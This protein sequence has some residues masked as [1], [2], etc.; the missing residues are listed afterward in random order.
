MDLRKIDKKTWLTAIA[1]VI[2]LILLIF[3]FWL[4]HHNAEGT[5]NQAN[6][7]QFT[8][9]Q[10]A[11]E[12]SG[13]K[14]DISLDPMPLNPYPGSVTPGKVRI[15]NAQNKLATEVNGGV[16]LF[17]GEALGEM[18]ATHKYVLEGSSIVSGTDHGKGTIGQVGGSWKLRED[19]SNIYDFIPVTQIDPTY[20]YQL[21]EDPLAACFVALNL[22]MADWLKSQWST[23]ATGQYVVIKNGQGEFSYLNQGSANPAKIIALADE[24]PIYPA[25]DPK[26]LNSNGINIQ[27]L[28]SG[29]KFGAPLKQELLSNEPANIKAARI[30]QLKGYQ[31]VGPISYAAKYTTDGAL[32]HYQNSVGIYTVAT[33]P[34]GE[35]NKFPNPK[36]P[37]QRLEYI[38]NDF[39]ANESTYGYSYDVTFSPKQL[40]GQANGKF[41]ITIKPQALPGKTLPRT[42]RDMIDLTIEQGYTLSTPSVLTTGSKEGWIK[43][44]YLAYFSG[45]NGKAL[46]ANKGLGGT[47]KV[48]DPSGDLPQPRIGLIPKGLGGPDNLVL[49]STGD[50]MT[51]EVTQ[52]GEHSILNFMAIRLIANDNAKAITEKYIGTCS[53]ILDQLVSVPVK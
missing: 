27:A 45:Y 16:R 33:V 29:I 22:G 9:E 5:D 52:T 50:T 38:T 8:Q 2:V 19:G 49:T 32:T 7:V 46:P 44:N 18:S 36:S 17:T 20:T 47:E 15:L 24:E 43:R 42:I 4:N 21:S 11:G 34:F 26:Y 14:I 25:A 10:K 40:N 39:Y 13:Y 30:A 3:L 35:F 6:E 28:N 31:V 37:N 1:V 12:K 53:M 41:T 23:N 51:V 48:Y